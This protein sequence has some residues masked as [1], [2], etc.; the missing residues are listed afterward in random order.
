MVSQMLYSW[1]DVHV[2]LL[3]ACKVPSLI[4][5]LIILRRELSSPLR[6]SLVCMGHPHPANNSTKYDLVPLLEDFPGYDKWPVEIPFLALL[7]VLIKI[8]FIDFRMLLLH[9]PST[10]DSDLWSW[11]WPQPTHTHFLSS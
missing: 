2:S 8:T 11:V 3:E 1:Y 4:K 10:P 7:R 5:E 6:N 9:H